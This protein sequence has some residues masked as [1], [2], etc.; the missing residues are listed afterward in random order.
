MAKKEK[1]TNGL[2][3]ELMAFVKKQFERQEKQLD[4]VESVLSLHQ[5]ILEKGSEDMRDLRQGQLLHDKR[6]DELDS[7][8][9]GISRAVDKDAVKVIDHERRIIRLEHSRPR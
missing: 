5:D 7:A 3:S 4:R 8:V 9:H 2:L 6:F 1:D